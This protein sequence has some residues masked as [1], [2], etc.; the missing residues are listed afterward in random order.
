[1]TE[2]TGII[3]TDLVEGAGETVHDLAFL[4]VRQIKCA[5]STPQ[6]V[7]SPYTLSSMLFDGT[8]VIGNIYGNDP[9]DSALLSCG[10]VKTMIRALD[11]LIHSG[12]SSQSAQ[13]TLCFVLHPLIYFLNI[14]P[15]Y[16][17]VRRALTVGLLRLILDAAQ[18]SEAVYTYLKRLV[19]QILTPATVY[20]SVLLELKKALADVAELERSLAFRESRIFPEWSQFADLANARI[21]LMENCNAGQHVSRKGCRNMKVSCSSS[22]FFLVA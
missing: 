15:G 19:T 10:V 1:M 16:P 8:R 22:S 17:T 18:Q 4:L 5:V 21:R 2:P 14:S 6:S 7:V 20:H 9:V 13:S 3:L 11:S 12:L